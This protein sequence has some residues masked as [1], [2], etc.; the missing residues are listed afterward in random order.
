MFS[1]CILFNAK[2]FDRLLE[3]IAEEEFQAVDLHH[4]YAYILTVI[5]SSDYV[6]TKHISC[7]LGLDS[8]TV[9]RMV[10]KL[11]NSGL[12]QKGS[13]RSSVDISL[14]PKGKNLM[15]EIDQA[16]DRYH[17]RCAILLVDVDVESLNESLSK[18]N[19]K[20]CSLK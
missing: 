2:K 13:E 8:S 18:A 6:K 14:T 1:K 16:W 3:A 5:A 4:S 12:V 19:S 15:P 20:L 10:K 11:E 7:E 17:E 9:T